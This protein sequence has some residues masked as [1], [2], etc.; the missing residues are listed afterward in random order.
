MLEINCF[1]TGCKLVEFGRYQLLFVLHIR[2]SG[3]QRLGHFTKLATRYM[4]STRNVQQGHHI[5]LLHI[6]LLLGIFAYDFI[7]VSAHN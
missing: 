5:R 7:I 4:E 2:H 3:Y 1:V 6:F